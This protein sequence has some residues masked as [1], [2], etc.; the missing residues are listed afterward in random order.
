MSR[1]RSTAKGA[2]IPGTA[3]APAPR[4]CEQVATAA[5]RPVPAVP[6]QGDLVEHWHESGLIDDAERAAF[7]GD[8]S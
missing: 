3:I 5:A 8:S 6:N 1:R 7:D 2:T 4:T